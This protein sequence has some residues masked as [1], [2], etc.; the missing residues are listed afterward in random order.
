[1]QVCMN[2]YYLYKPKLQHAI[3][4]MVDL[5]WSAIKGGEDSIDFPFI[6]QVIIHVHTLS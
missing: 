6:F 4:G 1:M 5:M 3:S 2:D